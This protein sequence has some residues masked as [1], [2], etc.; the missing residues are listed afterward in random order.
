MK[1][2]HPGDA[3][4]DIIIGHEYLGELVWCRTSH[5]GSP[6]PPHMY[7]KTPAWLSFTGGGVKQP[8]AEREN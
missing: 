4:M 5:S 1:V 7:K 2:S 6:A 8:A 3:Q